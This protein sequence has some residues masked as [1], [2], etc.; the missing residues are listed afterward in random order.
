MLA[1][2]L[3]F[4]SSEYRATIIFL[5]LGGLKDFQTIISNILP[6]VLETRQTSVLLSDY[7]NN[8]QACQLPVTERGIYSEKNMPVVH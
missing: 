4:S 7:A 1:K 8:L 3:F 5:L 2:H 6:L